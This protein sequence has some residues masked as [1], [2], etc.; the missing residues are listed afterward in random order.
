MRDGTWNMIGSRG[1]ESV[2]LVMGL[3]GGIARE[4]GQT[5]SAKRLCSLCLSARILANVKNSQ[6]AED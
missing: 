5:A 4:P 3:P 2:G 1:G 6:C